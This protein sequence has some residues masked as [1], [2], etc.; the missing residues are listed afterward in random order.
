MPSPDR[1]DAYVWA[2]TEPAARHA[3]RAVYLMHPEAWAFVQGLVLEHQHIGHVVELGS[4]NFNGSIRPLF[5]D[6]LS[7]TGVD[8]LPGYGVDVVADA[9]AFSP[10]TRARSHPVLRDARA[11][12]AALRTSSSMPRRILAPGGQLVVTC[13]TDPRAPHSAIDG[14]EL[15]VNEYYAN[16]PPDDLARWIEQAGLTLI[17]HQVH[18]PRGDLY[19]VAQKPEG[20]R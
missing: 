1:L 17:C 9:A 11:H 6:A 20:A 19:A 4:R 18:V 2:I 10:E 5:A 7:Y 13:A 16:V 14:G 3:R 15:Y 12:A 8:I